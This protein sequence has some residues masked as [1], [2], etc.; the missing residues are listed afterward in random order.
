MADASHRHQPA[1][2]AR[3]RLLNPGGRGNEDVRLAGLDLLDG[4]DVEI[5][6][7]R[8]SFLRHAARGSQPPDIRAENLKPGF[9]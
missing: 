4:T 7:L 1:P 2:V 9:E 5:G 8:Q 6:Q 3:Q